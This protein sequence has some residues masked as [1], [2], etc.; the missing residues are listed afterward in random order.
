MSLKPVWDQQMVWSDADAVHQDKVVKAVSLHFCPH[1]HPGGL[2][3][4]SKNA[5]ADSTGRNELFLNGILATLPNRKEPVEVVCV[6]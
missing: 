3:S 6:V 1:L 5:I 4:G 2:G